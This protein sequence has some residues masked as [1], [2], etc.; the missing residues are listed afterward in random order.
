MTG[1]G[2]Q[3]LGILGWCFEN[4]FSWNNFTALFQ[5]TKNE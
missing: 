1:I 4:Y 2:N 5:Q 3:E